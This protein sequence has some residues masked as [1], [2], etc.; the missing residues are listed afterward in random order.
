MKI[1]PKIIANEKGV[2][3]WGLLWAIGVPIPIL[4]VLFMVRGCT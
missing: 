1:L 3:G 4:P 2:L